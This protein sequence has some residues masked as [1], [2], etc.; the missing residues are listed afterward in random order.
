MK[1]QF[2][3][4]FISS[5]T[6]CTILSKTFCI[7]W[8]KNCWRKLRNGLNSFETYFKQ[9]T[10]ARLLESSNSSNNCP[11]LPI[12]CQK[13]P[14]F[15]QKDH[16]CRNPPST[17]ATIVTWDSLSTSSANYSS[18]RSTP[19]KIYSGLTRKWRREASRKIAAMIMIDKMNCT[20]LFI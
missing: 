5:P 16:T 17:A 2:W 20:T 19:K 11:L 1:K 18:L 9:N 6:T 15:W 13:P 7:D 10:K 3:K 4:S 8:C 12:T 14:I